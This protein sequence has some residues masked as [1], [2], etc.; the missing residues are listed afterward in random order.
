[1]HCEQ[2]NVAFSSYLALEPNKFLL[3]YPLPI[4]F[5]RPLWGYTVLVCHGEVRVCA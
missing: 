5:E 2:L 3:F 1:M 4:D